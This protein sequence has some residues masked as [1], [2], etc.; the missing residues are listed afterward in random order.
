MN[1][2]Y[3]QDDKLIPFVASLVGKSPVVGPVAKRSRFIFDRLNRAEDLRLDYDTTVLP[4]KKVF[5]PSKQ[6]LFTFD[7]GKF[8][9]ALD[10]QKVILFGVHPYDIKAIAITDQLFEDDNA[11]VNYLANRKAATIVGSSVQNHYKH[12]FFGSVCKDMKLSG[13]DAFLTKIRGGYVFQ[14]LTDKGEKLMKGQSFPE[15][16]EEQVKEAEGVNDNAQKECPN[17][18]G[19][20]AEEISR[21]VRGSFKSDIWKELSEDCLS[22]G[23]CN[24]VC[25]TCYCFDVQDEWGLGAADGKRYRRWDACLTPEFS[26]VSVQ[27]G[28]E[29]FRK[30]RS[31]RYRHRFMRKTTYLNEKLGVPACV[32]CGRCSGACTADIADPVRTIK[33][34]MEN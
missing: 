1:V 23:S 27:G 16:T 32:G 26:Q 11:D 22:C 6:D 14:V 9:S 33:K 5:F 12:A 13:H 25:P 10:P 30:D 28:T 17:K 4:P 7:G 2:Y 24:I 21:K 20:T 31:E 18:L 19:G 3:I 34:I 8:E 15:A 29:N